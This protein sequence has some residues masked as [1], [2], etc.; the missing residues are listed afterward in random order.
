M[1]EATKFT[2]DRWALVVFSSVRV[3][4]SYS[5][6]SVLLY[7]GIRKEQGKRYGQIRGK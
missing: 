3:K 7:E 2:P 6:D 5:Q 1:T 4:R